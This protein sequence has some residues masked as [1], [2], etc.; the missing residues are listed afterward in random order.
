MIGVECVVVIGVECVVMV[1]S[2]VWVVTV[3]T[4]VKCVVMVVGVGVMCEVV[5]VVRVECDVTIGEGVECE[6]MV[7]EIV[8]VGVECEVMV[9]GVTGVCEGVACWITAARGLDS[10]Y[11]KES[12]TSN[13]RPTNTTAVVCV[14]ACAEVH[15]HCT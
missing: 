4:G 1:E 11:K 8:G 14:R 12:N 13:Q 5:V 10:V 3:E 7:G 6:V 2:G 15:V 9:V